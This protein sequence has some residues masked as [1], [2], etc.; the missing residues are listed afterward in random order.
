MTG[1]TV[2]G[3]G[4]TPQIQREGY[5]QITETGEGDGRSQRSTAMQLTQSDPEKT[6]QLL[7]GWIGEED[8]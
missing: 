7:K 6:E 8:R 1:E 2:L 4:G 3:R 5:E